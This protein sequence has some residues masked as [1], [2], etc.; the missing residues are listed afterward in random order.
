MIFYLLQFTIVPLRLL[1]LFIFALVMLKL[2]F[3]GADLILLDL[4]IESQ[5]LTLLFNS[6]KLCGEILGIVQVVL[7]GVKL[8]PEF[9]EHGVLPL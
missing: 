5:L 7:K 9:T 8:V 1:Q 3:Q 6:V 2:D 4:R